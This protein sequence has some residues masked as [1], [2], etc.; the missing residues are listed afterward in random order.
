MDYFCHKVDY[1]MSRLR[2]IFTQMLIL[3]TIGLNAQSQVFDMISNKGDKTGSFTV[4]DAA[5]VRSFFSIDEL[6]V[7][8]TCYKKDSTR[9]LQ[10]PRPEKKYSHI[11][12][13]QLKGS[14]YTVFFSNSWHTDLASVSFNFETNTV[15]QHL[16]PLNL[17]KESYFSSFIYKNNL[18]FITRLKNAMGIRFFTFLEGGYFTTNTLNFKNIDTGLTSFYAAFNPDNAAQI[19]VRG[20]NDFNIASHQTKILVIDKKIYISLDYSNKSTTVIQIDLESYESA[21]SVYEQEIKIC[22]DAIIA[23]NSFIYKDKLFQFISCL[24]GMNL[25]I[26]NLSD[27]KILKQYA[28][29]DNEEIIF[30]NSPFIQKNSGSFKNDKELTTKQFIHKTSNSLG[31]VSVSENGKTLTVSLGGYKYNSSA[32]PLGPGG[33]PTGGSTSETLIYF[34]SVLS[35]D[36]FDHIDKKVY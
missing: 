34:E 22:E 1:Y 29:T 19:N 31:F 26:R 21:V 6:T 20:S 35:K 33:T 13:Y 24:S 17:N 4:I 18:Y 3:L 23:N 25:R 28:A 5:G 9:K 14:E 2:L 15:E 36:T 16:I 32:V 8:G 12:G 7:R 30:K 27:G 11:L 10:A